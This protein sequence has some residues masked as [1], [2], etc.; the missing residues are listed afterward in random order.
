MGGG[1]Q[2]TR[3]SAYSG[4]NSVIQKLGGKMYDPASIQ[5]ELAVQIRGPGT[6]GDLSNRTSFREFV[7][8]VQE[9]R[10]YLAMLGNQT[11]ASMIHTPGV[12]Y[13]LASATSTYQ[14]KVLVFIGD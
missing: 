6:P 8:N 11:H 9:F 2:P 10:V 14:G 13:S 12:Y 3:E 7:L 4:I 1:Q 5:A